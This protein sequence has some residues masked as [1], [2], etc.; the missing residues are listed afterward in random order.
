MVNRTPIKPRPFA[1]A[2]RIAPLTAA[3]VSGVASAATISVTDSGA[4]AT[5]GSCT[6]VDA[7]HS[8]NAD[9]VKAGCVV[10][11]D[12]PFGVNDTVDLTSF[13]NP[14]TIAFSNVFSD[15]ALTL[16]RAMTIRGDLD[17]NGQPLVTLAR[18]STPIPF[19]LIRSNSALIID[20][21]AFTGG[22]ANAIGGAIF[23]NAV[24]GLTLTHAVVTGNDAFIGGGIAAY[25]PVHVDN[26]IVS[27]NYAAFSGGGIACESL[28]VTA[29]VN[30]STVSGNYA[31]F[32]SG[33]GI[34]SRG[35]VVAVGSIVSGNF[36][37]QYGGGIYA[38][39]RAQLNGSSIT[40]NTSEYGG[41]GV[42]AVNYVQTL[43]STISDN[44]TAGNGGGIASQLNIAINQ[45]TVSANRSHSNGGGIAGLFV[46]SNNSTVSGN[47]A[48][49][50][51]GGVYAGAQFN[52]IFTTISS[53]RLIGNEMHSG[54]GAFFGNAIATLSTTLV[55]G[56]TGGADLDATGG[57]ISGDHN[58]IGVVGAALT[59]PD[60]TLTCDPHLAPLADN[61][62]PTQTQALPFGSCAIDAGPVTSDDDTD[63]R[64]TGF[65]RVVGPASDIG[66]FEAQT[67]DTIFKDGFE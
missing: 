7:V 28:C 33:G 46:Y 9:S 43:G 47:S 45:S 55:F 6:I 15:S 37:A 21:L 24:A 35:N 50:Y 58:L 20:G 8:I 52:T 18:Q 4:F 54:A 29:T 5:S 2:V 23:T 13:I 38:S 66:A 39:N 51:G 26:S 14:T 67:D 49:Q 34:Y 57:S 48:F 30:A 3:I 11:G 16:T 25:G 10:S 44:Y 64:G 41:G 17:S 32:G 36:A 56:N 61:G 31:A 53:N 1:S 65:A 63:Q 27:G 60:D 40:G 22:S 59:A 19:R 62:G 42:Y 12:D